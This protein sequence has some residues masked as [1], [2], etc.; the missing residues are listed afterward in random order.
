M[1][2]P[3]V[4]L[5]ILLGAGALFFNTQQ[6]KRYVPPP[7]AKPFLVFFKLAEKRYSLP[8]NLLVRVA[9]QE[10]NFNPTAQNPSGAKGMMQIIPKYHPSVKNPHDSHESV[11]YAAKY[12]RQLYDRFGSWQKALAAY[13]WGPTNVQKYGLKNLPEETK[14]YILEIGEDIPAARR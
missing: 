3:T 13:N 12:L 8:E 1:K 4:Y 14:N 7:K 9:Q 11:F 2:K 5:L 10:S 6:K